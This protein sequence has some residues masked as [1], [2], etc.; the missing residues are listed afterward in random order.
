MAGGARANRPSA[1]CL[2]DRTKLQ[3]ESNKIAVPADGGTRHDEIQRLIA[4]AEARRERQLEQ[5]G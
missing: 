5:P 2:V 1:A 4:I 3:V